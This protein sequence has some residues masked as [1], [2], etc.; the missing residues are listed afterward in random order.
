[1]RVWTESKRRPV[2]KESVDVFCA[3]VS[4]CQRMLTNSDSELRHRVTVNL[5]RVTVSEFGQRVTL[6]KIGQ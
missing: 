1:M 3:Q 4:G 6:S 5:D 2:V